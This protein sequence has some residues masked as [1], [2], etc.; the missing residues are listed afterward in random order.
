MN[1][2]ERRLKTRVVALVLLTT[3]APFLMGQEEEAQQAAA[4]P[5]QAVVMEELVVTATKRE[6]DLMM[7]PVAVSA[8]SQDQLT[9]QGAANITDLGDLVPNMQVGSSPSDSGVQVTVR[10]ITSNNFTELGDP[11][12]AIHVDGMY[13]ARPQAGLAL[14]HD[15]SRVEILRGPQG[16]LFGRNSTSGSINIVSSRPDTQVR[17]GNFEVD[18]GSFSKK[19]LRGWYNVPLSDTFAVRFSAMAEQQ[20]SYIDQ[21]SD[22][23]DLHFDPDGD[24]NAEIPA[25]GIPNTDQRRNTPVD[26]SEAYF[27]ID[28]RALR[29]SFR[30]EIGNNTDWQVTYDL[31][32]DQSPGGISLKDCEKAEGTFFECEHDQFYASINVP[33]VKD[34]DIK[35]LRSELSIDVS[36]SVL[37]EYRFADSTQD[38]SQQYDGDGGAWV[39]PDHPGYGIARF[40]CGAGPLVKDPGAFEAAGFP[41]QV[42]FPFEDLQ[43]TTRWSEYNS[44]VHEVQFKSTGAG[45]LNWIA[46]A[47]FMNEKN[48]I[49]FDVE[50]PFCCGGAI[51][52]AQSFVQPDRRVETEA[53]FAQFDYSFSQEL[54][55]T[56][57][58]RRTWDM[59]SDNGGSN[60][61]TSGYW[62][63]PG[64]YDPAG[65]FW[66]ESWGLIGVDP[67]WASNPAF[68]QA[69]VLTLEMGSLA[70]DFPDRIPGTDNTFEAEWAENTWR[71]GADYL[72]NDNL[73]AYGYV[74]TGFKAGGFGDKVDICECGNLTAFPYDPEEVI[75]YEFGLKGEAMGGDLRLLTS[76][77]LNDYNDMQRTTWAIVGKSIH[78][79][80]DIGTLLTT[81]LAE[82]D[83]SGAEFEWDWANPWE[84]GRFYGWVA[85][86]NAE[87]GKLEDGDDGLF[88]FERAYLNLTPCPAEDPNQIRGDNSLRRPADLSGNKLPWSPPFSFSGTFEH[89][90]WTANGFS[91]GPALTLNYQDEMFFNDNNYTDGPFHA[92]QDAV[93]TANFNYKIINERDAWAIVLFG[94]NITDEL[95]RSWAD[96]GPG[97]WRANFFPPRTVGARFSKSI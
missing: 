18:L 95:V 75:T 65:S 68:H 73:F 90:W 71:I 2:I 84:G 5:Q 16:T 61:Q 24:G 48:A 72:I 59:K 51:P 6:T 8:V 88:C 74:A 34:F 7:T 83:I 10:G 47:F 55:V 53:L 14:L 36:D 58:F 46:G 44:K 86:L 94:H 41:I 79:E 82:A 4:Q 89:T 70:E 13:T 54:N 80:R 9:D 23:F 92:G 15:V 49:R 37:F 42:Y 60:H 93:L 69:D 76:F 32:N 27:A 62:V 29:S 91:H 67:T 1:A 78:T 63:N 22:T 28:R 85:F 12:V 39:D 52:L 77:F 96:P 19:A 57:G 87:I 31:F 21:V 97:Y 50:L 35:T 17:E 25:D 30:W 56:A 20:D 11:T 26:A 40:C 38:R 45:D 64:A 43:L 3:G 33:G 81:N 66:Y